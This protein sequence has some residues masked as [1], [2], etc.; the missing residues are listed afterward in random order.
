MTQATV[1]MLESENP[2]ALEAEVYE[3][4][5]TDFKLKAEFLRPQHGGTP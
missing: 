2:R 1:D 4:L 3:R 5:A